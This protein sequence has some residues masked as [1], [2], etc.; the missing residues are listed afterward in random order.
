MCLH[1]SYE[2]HNSQDQ[3]C[4]WSRKQV[5][6]ERVW[7]SLRPDRFLLFAELF[8][9]THCSKTHRKSLIKTRKTK[10]VSKVWNNKPTDPVLKVKFVRTWGENKHDSFDLSPSKEP[11]HVLIYLWGTFLNIWPSNVTKHIQK[12]RHEPSK[13]FVFK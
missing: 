9:N 5:K 13:P 1:L 7:S 8:H 6:Q 3:N 10:D 12:R 4:L 11:Q 2:L